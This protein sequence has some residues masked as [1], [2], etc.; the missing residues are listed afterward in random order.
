MR[1]LG[2]FVFATVVAYYAVKLAN[3]VYDEV[4]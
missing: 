1:D 3:A 2:R 4:F